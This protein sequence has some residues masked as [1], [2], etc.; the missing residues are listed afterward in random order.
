MP[1]TAESPNSNAV[2]PTLGYSYVRFSAKRQEKGDSVR[3]QVEGYDRY[4]EEQG[5]TPA[6]LTL[7]DLGVSA[8]RGRNQHKGALAVFLQAVREGHVPTG[9]V[10]VVENLDRL[11]RQEP[12]DSVDVFRE[13]VNAGIKIATLTDRQEYTRESMRKNP[14]QF[15]IIVAIFM[16][17]YEESKTKSERVAAAWVEKRRHPDKPLTAQCPAWLTLNKET[18]KFE[19]NDRAGIMRRIIRL[20]VDNRGPASIA[21]RMNYE[22]VPTF[23]RGKQWNMSSVRYLLTSRTLLGE[24]QPCQMQGK[25]HVP[26]GPP[27]KGYY[28]A[29]C[30]EADFYRIQHFV[31]LRKRLHRGRT[32]KDIANLFGRLLVCGH[33]DSRMVFCCGRMGTPKLRSYKTHVGAA[34]SPTFPYKPFEFHFLGWVKEVRLGEQTAGEASNLAK[35]EGQLTEKQRHVE[36]AKAKA[37]SSNGQ[38]F[39]GLL[40]LIEKLDGQVAGLQQQVEWERAKQHKPVPTVQH[41]ELHRLV[42]RLRTL[43]DGASPERK[44]TRDRIRTA[45]QQVVERVTVWVF[46]RGMMQLCVCNVALRDG[47]NRLLC[48]RVERYK[49]PVSWSDGVAFSWG[50]YELDAVAM[51]REL[52]THKTAEDMR[53]A[54]AAARM[55]ALRKVV[56]G[57]RSTST[58]YT[59]MGWDDVD[60]LFGTA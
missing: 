44:E 22:G 25:Q 54:T 45:I 46:T 31:G 34:H 32:G 13:I 33:D 27:I 57:N 9:S 3:R 30:T 4:C 18:S 6:D 36:K 21:N 15:F 58:G 5:L 51:G 43:P 48:I 20:A 40:D 35:L 1:L 11:S 16:R 41:E 17:A 49:K 55:N 56:D 10:L 37:L 42:E 53:M 39:E 19:F 26:Q 7:H 50:K 28:P 38:R 24:F 8:F 2:S 23:R 12:L 47:L 59:V 29:I 52:L 60:R 14:A